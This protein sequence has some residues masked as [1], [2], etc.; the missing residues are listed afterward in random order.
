MTLN[1]L[2]PLK[3]RG[4]FYSCSFNTLPGGTL[5]GTQA[6]RVRP[7]LV[8]GMVLGMGD[9]GRGHEPVHENETQQQRPDQP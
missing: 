1:H 7:C 5:P 2:N 4:E 3:E 8:I 9:T 6:G